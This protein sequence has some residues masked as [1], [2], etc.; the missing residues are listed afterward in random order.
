MLLFTRQQ[1]LVTMQFYFTAQVR[2][3]WT[4]SFLGHG[5]N[6][7]NWC[8]RSWALSQSQSL[9]CHFPSY[10]TSLPMCK[11]IHVAIW[12]TIHDEKMNRPPLRT[13]SYSMTFEN[14]LHPFYTALFVILQKGT[15]T[16]SYGHLTSKLNKCSHMVFIQCRQLYASNLLTRVPS[17]G[18]SLEALKNMFYFQKL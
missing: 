16:G 8:R 18:R 10:D 5:F 2:L 9:T 4:I 6:E 14:G 15:R 12:F 7:S 13:F 11:V 17:E 1:P 3:N